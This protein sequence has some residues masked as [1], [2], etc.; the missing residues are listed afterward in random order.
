[1]EYGELI[2]VVRML[3][4]TLKSES[5]LLTGFSILFLT[6]LEISHLNYLTKYEANVARWEVC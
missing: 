6:F 5:H 2:K 1:M 3:V 4:G